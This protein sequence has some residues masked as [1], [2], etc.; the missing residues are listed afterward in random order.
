MIKSAFRKSGIV[1]FKPSVVLSQFLSQELREESEPTTP[2]RSSTCGPHNPDVL[3][4]TPLTIRSL[5]RQSE[6][7]YE[8]APQD[9]PE[10]TQVLYKFICGSVQQSTEGLQSMCDFF[11]IYFS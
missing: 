11:F 8:N 6:I 4:T 9:D 5:K 10:F 1:P 7:L 3:K 2:S